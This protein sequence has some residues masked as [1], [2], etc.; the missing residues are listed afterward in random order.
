MTATQNTMDRYRI[1][2]KTGLSQF[3]IDNGRTI[4]NERRRSPF[5]LRAQLVQ[6]K[7]AHGSNEEQL[8]MAKGN[9]IFHV[10]G[11]RD[12]TLSLPEL[13]KRNVRGCYIHRHKG[14][15]KRQ[16]RL[17]PAVFGAH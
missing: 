16:H 13:I 12:R 7:M 15:V 4:P 5:S 14:K 8:R 17:L 1:D 3:D 11:P 9:N 6:N 2:P 10:G